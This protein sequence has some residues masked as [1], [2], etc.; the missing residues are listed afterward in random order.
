VRTV[1]D[2]FGGIGTTLASAIEVG[3]KGIATE[4]SHGYSGDALERLL[5]L[6]DIIR[7]AA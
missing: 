2:P 7:G 4:M 5:G 1:L 6:C 3:V